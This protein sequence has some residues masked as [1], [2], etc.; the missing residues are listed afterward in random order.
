VGV[1][2]SSIFPLPLFPSLQGRGINKDAIHPRP[3]WRGILACFS[4]GNA[5]LT[6]GSEGSQDY[7]LIR[8]KKDDLNLMV[9]ITK[10]TD[11]VSVNLLQAKGEEFSW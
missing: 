4:K 2:N 3:K 8:A 7:H 11:H 9:T 10:K 5:W 6:V 1:K